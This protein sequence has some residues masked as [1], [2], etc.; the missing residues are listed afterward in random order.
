[1][2]LAKEKAFHEVLFSICRP[3]VLVSLLLIPAAKTASCREG[4]IKNGQ[5]V[6]D[7]KNYVFTPTGMNIAAGTTVT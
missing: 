3:T 5:D 2:V 1:L 6:I 4:R 7:V